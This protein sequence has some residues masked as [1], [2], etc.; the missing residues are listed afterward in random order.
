MDAF[1]RRHFQTHDL[2][3]KVFHSNITVFPDGSIDIMPSM[4]RVL[5]YV[6]QTL[7]PEQIRIEFFYSTIS[8][9]SYM[10]IN[11]L[12]SIHISNHIY[13]LNS[14][15]LSIGTFTLTSIYCH[16]NCTKPLL[17]ENR[18]VYCLLVHSCE[19]VSF[20]LWRHSKE[21]LSALPETT[22]V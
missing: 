18:G 15:C 19:S 4:V 9:K 11:Y 22:I 12:I 10:L 16:W 20:A 21:I 5:V 14:A 7:L 2:D 6:K 17:G 13:P 3:S 1:C 8:V